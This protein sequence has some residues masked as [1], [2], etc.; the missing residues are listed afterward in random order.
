MKYFM[1]KFLVSVLI[2]YYEKYVKISKI[3]VSN[4]IFITTIIFRLLLM[5]IPRDE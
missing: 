3:I 1:R 2:K 5:R 4:I